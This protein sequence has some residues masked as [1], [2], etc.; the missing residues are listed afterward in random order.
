[1]SILTTEKKI[2]SVNLLILPTVAAPF[3][4][5]WDEGLSTLW[6]SPAFSVPSNMFQNDLVQPGATSQA[7]LCPYNEEEP[8]IWFRL[9]EAQFASVGI[10]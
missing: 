7:K 9:M 4:S 2:F 6:I 3:F 10:F 8:H 1:V 5:S